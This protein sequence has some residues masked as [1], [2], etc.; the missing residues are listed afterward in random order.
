MAD[1]TRVYSSGAKSAAKEMHY[2]GRTISLFYYK[3][4]THRSSGSVLVAVAT[5]YNK[6]F[7]KVE[8]LYIFFGIFGCR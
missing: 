2:S 6:Q 7:G 3:C 1:G 4:H 5:Q 8:V